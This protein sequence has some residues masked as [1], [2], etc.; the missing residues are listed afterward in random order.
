[1]GLTGACSAE[2]SM[3]GGRIQVVCSCLI[4]SYEE[5]HILIGMKI[6]ILLSTIREEMSQ[7]EGKIV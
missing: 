2:N 6:T 5:N 4:G 3:G 7:I 1:M